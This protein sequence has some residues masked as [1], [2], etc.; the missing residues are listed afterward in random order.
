MKVNSRLKGIG[1]SWCYKDTNLQ[2]KR[3]FALASRPETQF[4]QKSMR[5]Q[6]LEKE[7]LIS[8]LHYA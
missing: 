2:G 6:K 3:P 7:F 4:F 5:Y 8:K 1:P